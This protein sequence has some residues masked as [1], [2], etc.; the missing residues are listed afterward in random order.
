MEAMGCVWNESNRAERAVGE[1]LT[2]VSH[3]AKWAR[4]AAALLIE[5]GEQ[6]G[7]SLM[8]G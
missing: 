2:H 6:S 4:G 8:V 1:S 7:I 5:R 3:E